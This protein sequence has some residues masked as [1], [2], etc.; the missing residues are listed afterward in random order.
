MTRAY[1]YGR[2]MFDVVYCVLLDSGAMAVVMM[3]S[4]KIGLVIITIEFR[5]R[6]DL[7]YVGWGVKL[8]SLTH[9]HWTLCQ[10][11]A[12]YFILSSLLYRR[13]SDDASDVIVITRRHVGGILSV[14]VYFDWYVIPHTTVCKHRQV[15]DVRPILLQKYTSN[16]AAFNIVIESLTSPSSYI[17]YRRILSSQ[18][19]LFFIFLYFL[20]LLSAFNSICKLHFNF[21]RCS[22]CILL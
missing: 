6:N 9:H 5:L 16:M 18:C 11:N 12:V 17:A 15:Y 21:F 14:T 19:C 8:Y 10:G 7:Y 4:T 3:N 1:Q 20:F 2:S 13:C 22:N